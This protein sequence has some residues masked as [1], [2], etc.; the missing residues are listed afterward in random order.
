MEVPFHDEFSADSDLYLLGDHNDILM[1]VPG[2]IA[3]LNHRLLI[4]VSLTRRRR[5]R[6][7][8]IAMR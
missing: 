8:T 2:R 5:R 3:G 4:K 6:E 1:T 7:T